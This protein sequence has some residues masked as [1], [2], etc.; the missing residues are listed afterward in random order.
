MRELSNAEVVLG[1]I[2]G[3]TFVVLM[4]YLIGDLILQKW[5]VNPED[6]NLIN[7]VDLACKGLRE[8]T[9]TIAR[10]VVFFG[11]IYYWPYT[12]IIMSKQ[13]PESWVLKHPAFRSGELENPFTKNGDYLGKHGYQFIPK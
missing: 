6:A 7:M 10:R 9:I 13:M 5:G 12:G 1:I 4:W 2:G 8:E 11:R 3:I